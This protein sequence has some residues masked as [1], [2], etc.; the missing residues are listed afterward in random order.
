MPLLD[1][2]DLDV[3]YGSVRAV[4][5][6]SLQVEPGQIVTLIG[7]NGA[8]KST[9]LNAISG[10]SPAC[11]GVIRF[12]DQTIS[13]LPSHGIVRLGISQVPEGRRV[14]GRLTVAENLSLG[15]FTRSDAHGVAQDR[16]RVLALFP[17]LRERLRQV[18]GTLSGGEQQMLSM[19]RALMAAPRMLLLDEPSMGLAPMLVDQIFEI[20]QEINR[21]GIAILLVEQNAYAAL[22]I[23]HKAYV[24]A[25]GTIVL[26]G[27]GDELLRHDDVVSAYL[28][29]A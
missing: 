9:T 18:A 29:E 19:A 7:A 17:R 11:G 21:Q 10:L 22:A 26:E 16:D 27:R 23:S 12:Q 28:G 5:R 1:V 3:R 15:S 8:G 24:L 2:C 20:V 13:T 6:I 14:F 4:H 25:N